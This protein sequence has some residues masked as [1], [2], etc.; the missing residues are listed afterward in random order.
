MFC[1]VLFLKQLELHFEVMNFILK[2]FNVLIL[3]GLFVGTVFEVLDF[4]SKEG[5]F[6]GGCHVKAL[7]LFL[8]I[9]RGWRRDIDSIE[10][11]ELRK[12]WVLFH[13][14]REAIGNN[15]MYVFRKWNKV[16]TIWKERL[17]SI[18][19]NT[20]PIIIM[21]MSLFY[22]WVYGLYFII[23][24]LFLIFYFCCFSNRKVH[25][26]PNRYSF[27]AFHFNSVR[28]CSYLLLILNQV[29]GIIYYINFLY[30]TNIKWKKLVFA[31][32]FY[33]FVF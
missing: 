5:W 12:R 11:L 4:V 18:H 25:N 15:L 2:S 14:D 32:F 31:L 20:D 6:G 29:L 23:I 30:L 16:W 28:N 26:V 27:S 7:D 17:I 21:P 13:N 33:F 24:I 8:G 22:L 1:L 9:D 10:S 3:N 19:F